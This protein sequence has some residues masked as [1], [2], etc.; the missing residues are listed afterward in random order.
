MIVALESKFNFEF[1]DGKLL[2]TAFHDVKDMV[3]CVINRIGGEDSCLWM[4]LT[5]LL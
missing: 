2:F 3:N 1:E 5:R 4:C